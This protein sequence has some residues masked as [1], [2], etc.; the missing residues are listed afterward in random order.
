[1]KVA[2]ERQVHPAWLRA[3]VATLAMLLV[4]AAASAQ[5]STGEVDALLRRLAE[6]GCEFRRHGQWHDAGVATE[7]LRM[8]HRYIL[9]ARPS[10]T[11][12]EFIALG[13]TASST[14]RQ[15]YRVRCPGSA[16]QAGA[17]WMTGQLEALRA[18]RQP[19]RPS[20]APRGARP[21]QPSH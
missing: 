8:K 17:E 2:Y 15:P 21:P 20:S 10:L 12:E 1:M 14:T 4:A 11:T 16:E 3:A 9:R 19:A 7:H 5:G 13:A 18:A 6:S